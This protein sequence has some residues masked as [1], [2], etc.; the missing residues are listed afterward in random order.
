MPEPVPVLQQ[1]L[2]PAAPLEATK[3]LG[4]HQTESAFQVLAQEATQNMET[5]S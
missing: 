5:A 3:P 2:P 4:I 1:D